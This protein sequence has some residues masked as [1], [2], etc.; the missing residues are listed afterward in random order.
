MDS[1]SKRHGYRGPAPEIT[2]REDAP[3]VVRGYILSALR[4][5]L[6]ASQARQLICSTLNRLPDRGNWSPGNVWDE[7]TSHLE[8]CEWF[9]VY[10]LL[11]AVYRNLLAHQNRL[12]AGSTPFST[13]EFVDDLNQMFEE[14][15]IGWKMEHGQILARGTEAFEVIIRQASPALQSV[16]MQT[17]S[18]ELHKAIQAERRKEMEDVIADLK[19]WYII[20]PM[21]RRI[22]STKMAR[23]SRTASRS[24]PLSR[25]KVSAELACWFRSS[26]DS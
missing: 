6:D 12:M 3:E 24:K 16:G 21:P 18:D 17:S 13:E 2:I 26:S 4:R 5:Y 1:F 7:V 9:R 23:S 22:A 11:E 25:A 14:N 10:D 15:G 19:S 20:S 8:N